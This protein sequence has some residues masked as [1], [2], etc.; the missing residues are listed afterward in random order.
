[1]ATANAFHAAQVAQLR[2]S[3]EYESWLTSL[4]QAGETP[5]DKLDEVLFFQHVP[6]EWQERVRQML[7]EGVPKKQIAGMIGDNQT[8]RKGERRAA[9]F[10]AAR[11]GERDQKGNLV[12]P[13]A[14]SDKK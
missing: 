5:F 13:P 12:T 14:T 6:K 8:A 1:M 2:T 3:G 10:S 11:G 9:L 7:A 4:K